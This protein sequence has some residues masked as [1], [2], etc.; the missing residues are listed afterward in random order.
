[1]GIEGIT[2]EWGLLTF[3][4]GTEK[5]KPSETAILLFDVYAKEAGTVTVK[6]IADYSGVKTEYLLKTALL[7]GNV[8]QNVKMDLSKFKTAEGMALK[9]LNKINALVFEVDCA[10]YLINNALWV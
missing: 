9:S 3:K 1:M 4:M 7:G 6:L 2:C 5:Y 10:N 8:W